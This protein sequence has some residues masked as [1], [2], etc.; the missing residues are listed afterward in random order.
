MTNVL[1][2]GGSGFLGSALIP[3]LLQK[4]NKVYALSRHPPE[5]RENLIPLEGDILLP[6]LGLKEV[7]DDISAVHH[8]AAQHKLGEDR[9]GSIWQTNVQGTKNVIDFCTKYGIQHLYF[10]STAYVAGRNIYERSKALCETMVRESGIPQVT[11]F[12]PSIVMGTPQH[13]YPGHLAQFVAL[14][15]KVHQRAEVVRRKIEG[16]MRL[17]VIEP[18]FHMKANPGGRLN[19]ISIDDVTSAMAAIDGVGT[20]WL[21]HPDP[22]TLGQLVE[23]VSESIMVRVVITSD[24][25]PTPIEAAFEKMSAAFTPYLWG[26]DFR[27][28]L[29]DLPPI[30]KE[31]IQDTIKRTL[32]G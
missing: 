16:A 6:D 11:I 31:F 8:L 14:L 13:F 3:K 9:D 30:T 1:I 29:K 10:T 28:D 27:S 7:P 20:Y 24:F 2:T 21:T 12:K 15:V 25:K 5:A 4:G 26:D 17:P 18:V 19:L 23:W 32:I 22:P